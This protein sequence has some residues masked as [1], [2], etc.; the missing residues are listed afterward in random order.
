MASFFQAISME[1]VVPGILQRLRAADVI[2]MAGLNAASQ[3]QEYCRIGAVH[4]AQRR[5]TALSGIVRTSQDPVAAQDNDD[6][7][8]L[9]YV[10]E[11]EVQSETTWTSACTCEASSALLCVHAAALLYHWLAH[12]EEFATRLTEEQTDGKAARELLRQIPTQKKESVKPIHPGSS[13][14]PI[15]FTGFTGLAGHTS[16]STPLAEA[17]PSWELADLLEQMGLGE[18]RNIAREYDAPTSGLSRQQLVESL[19][20][21]MRQP[22]AVRRIAAKL[23]KTQRQLLAAVTLAGGIV[24]DDDLRGLFERFGLGRP[25]SQ[26]QHA[27]ST[28]QRKAL[29]FRT[30][31][32]TSGAQ[33]SGVSGMLLDIHWFVPLEV[34][35]ALRVTVPTTIFSTEQ[36]GQEQQVTLRQQRPFRLLDDLLLVARAL[37][38]Y[39]IESNSDRQEHAASLRAAVEAQSNVNANIRGSG[40]DGSVP[41]PPPGDVPPSALVDYLHAQLSL[42]PE[43]LRFVIRLL[44]LA[45]LLYR[46]DENASSLRALPNVAELLL[47]PHRPEI[48]RDL[49]TLWVTQSSYT[50]LYDLQEEGLHLRCRG[51]ALNFPMLRVGELDTENR[52]ARQILLSLL[53]QVPSLQWVSFHA[54]ARFVWRLHPLFLQRKQRQYAAPHWWIER[55][56]GRPL[57][58]LRVQEWFQ[59][60]ALYLSRLLCGPLSWWGACDVALDQDGH[61]LAFRLTPVAQ[62]LF[63]GVYE[64]GELDETKVD[65]DYH[66]A[67]GPL[68]LEIVGAEEVRIACRASLW[69]AIAVLE[70]FAQTAGVHGEHL[71]YFVTPKALG[72]ALSKGKQPSR[73]VNLL[74][75]VAERLT[76]PGPLRMVEQLERWIASY[77]RTRLYTGV[78]LLETVDTVVMRELSVTTALDEQVIQTIHPTLRVVKRSGAEQ[79]MDEL[80]KRGQPALLHD[81][82]VYGAD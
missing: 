82:D 18:L 9:Y 45:E 33:R 51:T 27:L 77:G 70:A 3:G 43:I 46:D 30:S 26:L 12:P 66:T 28:L 4:D 10:V 74:R 68:E 14:S 48:A 22:E 13:S 21:T 52:D 7:G 56:H 16:L 69:P 42:P 49:F 62:W 54:F 59:A 32:N 6:D 57:Q 76:Q 11:V 53:A 23:E 60:E 38:G 36:T 41:M 75:P 50:E 29:L 8:P 81:E 71:R 73:L 19:A 67:T 5:G 55:E 47:G 80:K 34:R 61:L 35:A 15:T 79:I 64:N 63:H 25:S 78:T 31:L 2:R 20:E 40:G 17:A 65:Q 58:P 37:D 1:Y 24:S 39:H 44:R 72:E